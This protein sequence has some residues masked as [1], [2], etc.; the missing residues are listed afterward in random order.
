[1]P[2]NKAKGDLFHHLLAYVNKKWGKE[3]LDK[4]GKVQDDFNA[5]DWYPFSELCGLLTDINAKMGNGDGQAVNRMGTDMIKNDFRWRTIFNGRN[6]AY[7]FITTKRQDTQYIGGQ[8]SARVVADKNIRINMKGWECGEVWYEF[9]KG[10]L[11]GVLE[12]TG[13]EGAV[14]MTRSGTG[15]EPEYVYDI[16]WK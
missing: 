13:H 15:D 8:Y 3:G 9:V 10:R 6:P 2:E 1:M 12:L 7:V 4:L 16:T 14:N 11:Q 5:A